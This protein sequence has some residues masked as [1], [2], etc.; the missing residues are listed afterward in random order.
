[1]VGGWR[2]L[3]L[4]VANLHLVPKCPGWH[5]SK[6]CLLYQIYRNTPFCCL[7]ITMASGLMCSVISARH[8]EA[9]SQRLVS[10]MLLHESCEAVREKECG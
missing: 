6:V 2:T 4:H 5:P 8:S 3:S 7:S 10:Q 9:K 1:M